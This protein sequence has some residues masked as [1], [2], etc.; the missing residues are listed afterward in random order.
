MNLRIEDDSPR[1]ITENSSI[2]AKSKNDAKSYDDSMTKS[3]KTKCQSIT[4]ESRKNHL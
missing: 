2:R 4:N 1:N 3:M